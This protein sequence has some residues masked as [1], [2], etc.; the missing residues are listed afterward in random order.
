MA[1]QVGQGALNAN[2]IFA[3]WSNSGGLPD[4]WANYYTNSGYSRGSGGKFGSPYY[5]NWATNSG[6]YYGG[7]DAVPNITPG[8]MYVMAVDIKWVSGASLDGA[9]IEIDWLNAA[10]TYLGQSYFLFSVT[11][12]A[13]GAIASAAGYDYAWR[14]MVVAPATAVSAQIYLMQN[15]VGWGDVTKT[16]RWY[17]ASLRPVT[18]MEAAVTTS[19]GVVVDVA[20]R[21]AT[22]QWEAVT[23]VGGAAAA[24]RLESKSIGGTA[25]S[26]VA[27]EAYEIQLWNDVAGT[28]KKALSVVGGDAIFYGSITAEAGIF[29]GTGIKWSPQ[30]QMKDFQVTDGQAVSFGYDLGNTPLFDFKG[31][32]LAPLAT[33]ETYHLYADSASKTGFTARLRISTPGATTSYSLTTD[34]TPGTGPTR[35]IDKASNPDANTNIYTFR[36]QGSFTDVAFTTGGGGGGGW[37]P[38]GGGGQI[39]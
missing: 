15:F 7:F 6:A 28:R 20:A 8:S 21:I 10:G 31:N 35:Q 29:L 1:A 27:L 23:S 26:S 33:G 17:Q 34:T 39:P 37:G 19:S 2:P 38:P 18:D 32:G 9:G 30:L 22:A 25:S 12:T 14:R 13:G 5:L 11:P 36:V 3:A 4:S 16:L 24:I